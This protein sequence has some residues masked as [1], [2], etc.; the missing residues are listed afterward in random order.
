MLRTHSLQVHATPGSNP[1]PCEHEGCERTFKQSVHLKAHIKTH[2][3]SSPLSSPTCSLT[4]VTVTR[5]MCSHVACLPLPLEERQY[6]NWSALQKHSKSAHPPRCPYPECAGKKFTTHR[7]LKGHLDHHKGVEGTTRKRRSRRKRKR[8]D[9][10]ETEETE[11][12]AIEDTE[13]GETEAEY[14]VRMESER[15]ERLDVVVAANK[16]KS[17]NKKRKLV[18]DSPWACDVGACRKNFKSVRPHFSQA[19]LRD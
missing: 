16:S 6:P 17:D 12:T 15:D 2:D 13:E 14:E 19:V 18:A 4:N 5:Y 7:G 3:R 10:E 9:E 1:F 11:T 8:S